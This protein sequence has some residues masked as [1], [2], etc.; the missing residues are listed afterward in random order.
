MIAA[1]ATVDSAA[2]TTNSINNGSLKEKRQRWA[3]NTRG[4][5]AAVNY[6]CHRAGGCFPS[7]SY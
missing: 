3:E 5:M 6:F 4:S 1:I 7:V 2:I